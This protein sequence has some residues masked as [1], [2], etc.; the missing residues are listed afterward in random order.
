MYFESVVYNVSES[1]GIAL[2]SL[3]ADGISQFPY[4]VFLEVDSKTASMMCVR[5]LA[6]A[7]TC[8]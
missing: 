3:I 2:I 1:N 4:F 8:L 5:V 6:G 7:F